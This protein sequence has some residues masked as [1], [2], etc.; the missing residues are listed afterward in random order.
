MMV[1]HLTLGVDSTGSVA[2]A[3]ISALASDAAFLRCTVSVGTTSELTSVFQTDFKVG[4]LFVFV[5]FHPTTTLATA[6]LRC[7][8]T[9]N[10]AN[11]FAC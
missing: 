2:F 5:A 8:I 6:F 3:Q 4:T 1:Q 9:I 11:G 10:T 7:T